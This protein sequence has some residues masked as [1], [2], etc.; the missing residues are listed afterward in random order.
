MNLH[1]KGRKLQLVR[2]LWHPQ[3]LRL[4]GGAQR[5]AELVAALTAD[6][7]ASGH[8]MELVFGEGP[9]RNGEGQWGGG[10]AGRE[11]R[12]EGQGGEGRGHTATVRGSVGGGRAGRAGSEIRREE[13]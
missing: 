12:G 5:S 2:R 8:F 6:S 11:G 13:G 7:D 1:T 3:T 4:P 10:W 9:H